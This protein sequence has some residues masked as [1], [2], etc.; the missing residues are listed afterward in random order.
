MALFWP[1]NDP[2][3]YWWEIS[4]VAFDTDYGWWHLIFAIQWEKGL[5]EKEDEVSIRY[6]S[7]I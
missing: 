3:E 6:N 1:D 5:D 7:T 2:H 4:F